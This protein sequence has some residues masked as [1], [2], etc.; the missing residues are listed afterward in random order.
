MTPARRS[1]VVRI[2][3]AEE[4]DAADLAGLSGQLGYAATPEQSRQRLRKIVPSPK[5][6]VYVAEAEDGSVVGWVHV[7]ANHLLESGTRAEIN[8]LVVDESK[9]SLGAGKRLLEEA[10]GWARAQEIGRASCRERVEIWVVAGAL[11]KEKKGERQK[12][13]EEREMGER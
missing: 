2:R 1:A 11:E 13:N 4:R 10:E 5:D 6:A 7:S 8:G 12:S 9:R 3:R